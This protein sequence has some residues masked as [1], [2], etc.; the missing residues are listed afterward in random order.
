MFGQDFKRLSG[1]DL[2]EISRKISWPLK[3]ICKAADGLPVSGLKLWED[4]MRRVT[5]F[6]VAAAVLLVGCGQSPQ[7]KCSSTTSYSEL[8][9]LGHKLNQSK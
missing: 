9:A 5:A 1:A 2:F 6:S 7:E 8:R 3:S 4:G